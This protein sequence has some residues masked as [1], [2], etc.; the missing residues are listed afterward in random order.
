MVGDV[1]RT[2]QLQGFPAI[3]DLYIAIL[4]GVLCCFGG[5]DVDRGFE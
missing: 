3:S 1:R 2:I 4:L 5:V